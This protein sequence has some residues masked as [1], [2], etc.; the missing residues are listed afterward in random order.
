MR[1][2]AARVGSGEGRRR[3]REEGAAARVDGG[4]GRRRPREEEGRRLGQDPKGL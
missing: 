2:A 1:R 4:G 3:P